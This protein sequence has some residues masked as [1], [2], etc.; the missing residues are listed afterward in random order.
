MRSDDC[1]RLSAAL[2]FL[3]SC[4]GT[5]SGPAAPAPGGEAPDTSRRG[6]LEGAEVFDS[7]GRPVK[8]EPP[9]ASCP[10]V[11]PDTAFLDRCRLGGY[12]VRKCGCADLCAGDVSAAKRYFDASGNGKDCTPARADCD[13]PPAS[14]AFQDACTDRGFKLAQCGCEWL[15]SGNTTK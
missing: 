10:D 9:R 6:A 15:C 2:V 8:C 5:T 13:A 12:Q 7:D 11:P 4:G 14:T 3:L 1:A